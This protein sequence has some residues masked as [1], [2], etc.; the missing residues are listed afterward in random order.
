[1]NDIKSLEPSQLYQFCDLNQFHFSTTDELE[2]LSEIIGQARAFDAIQFGTGIRRD[3][4]NVFVLGPPGMGKHTLVRQFL[5]N[6]ALQESVPSDLCYVNNFEQPH[7]PKA[8]FLPAG[9]GAKLRQDM[10]QLVEELRVAIPAAFESDEYRAKAETIQEEFTEHQESAFRDLGQDAEKQGVALLKTP[11]GFAFAPTRNDEVIN[12]EEYDKLPQEEKTRIENAIDELQDRLQKI[13]RQIPQWRKE[14]REKVKHLNREITLFAVGNQISE[15]RNAYTDQPT[16]LNYLDAVQQNIIENVNDFRKQEEMP[17][18]VMGISIIERPSFNRYQVNLLVD[19][20]ES[21]GSPIIYED[22]PMYS[23]LVGRVEHI[24]QM[25]ALVTDFTLIKPGSLHK[26][27]GGYLL[28]DVLKVLGQPFGWEG[29]KRALTSREVRIESLGQ[30][31]SLVSTVSLE[32]EPVPLDVKIILFGDRIFYYLLYEY[33][34]EFSELFKV[35]A[36]FEDAVDRNS[37]AN[38]LYAR[39]IGTLVRKWELFPFDRTAVARVIEHSARVVGDSE[40]LST[41]MQ[42]MVNLLRESDYWARQAGKTIVDAA[43][44]QQAIDK[45]IHRADRLR[46]KMHESI[47]RGTMMIDTQG[48]ITGQVNGLSVIELGNF[49]FALPTR[50]TATTRLG[51]G[52]LINIERE[53]ELSGAIHSKGVL[54]LSAFLAERYAKNYPLSLSAS[55]TFEQSYGMVEGDSASVAELCALLSNLSEVPI[56][57]SLA[58]TGSVNQLGQV[59]AI[60][61]VNEKIEGFFDI[62]K[63][64]GLTGEQGVLIP[65][66]NVKHLMLR[67]DIVDAAKTG[68]FHIYPIENVDQAIE[69]LTSVSSGIPDS[70]GKFP[71]ESINFRVMAKL[72]DLSKIRQDFTSMEKFTKPWKKK[73]GGNQ[74]K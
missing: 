25:G 11:S 45:Q 23:N 31:L 63:A 52:E 16:I 36:D 56:K 67:Q 64:R 13:I 55:L 12:P 4:Y 39:L 44:V 7:K 14:K 72:H 59:Q 46:Q 26:A 43:E 38:H 19:H 42:S 65:A 1:M 17:V 2:D 9:R 60:G 6:K 70:V 33:D 18:A 54:I 48:A 62:C 28:L 3:G 21:K 53:V 40:K 57:Q 58:I 29:L 5:E 8:L 47:L 30:M 34:P 10:Q 15:I 41:H 37:E 50:I 73:R 24:A 71:P 68:Q 61:G 22:N 32:P 74:H 66:T 69:I 27:N 49:S 20:S 35:A 51:N